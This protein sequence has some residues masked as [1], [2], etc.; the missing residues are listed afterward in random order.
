MGVSLLDYGL[1]LIILGRRIGR[2]V[3]VV[4]AMWIPFC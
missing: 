2:N 1:G 4:F 3:F